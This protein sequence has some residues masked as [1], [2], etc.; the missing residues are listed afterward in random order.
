[1]R[2]A[3]F[4]NGWVKTTQGDWVPLAKA[5]FTASNAEWESK[6]NIDAGVEA[7]AFYLATGGDL[8]KTREL[9]STISL[10]EIPANPPR[11]LA[12]FAEELNH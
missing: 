11:L 6:E 8:K 5:R 9:K 12:A 4:G 7:G 1:M 2:R 3:R 10:P